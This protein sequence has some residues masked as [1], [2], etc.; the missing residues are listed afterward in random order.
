M[1]GRLELVHKIRIALGRLVMVNDRLAWA[2]GR[3]MET[4]AVVAAISTPT[5]SV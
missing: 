2:S 3:C 1:A 5:K 4:A